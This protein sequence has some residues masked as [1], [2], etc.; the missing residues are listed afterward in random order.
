VLGDKKYAGTGNEL[1]LAQPRQMLHA[2]RLIFPH[3]RTRETIRAIAPL[4]PDF[5]KC[6]A[7]MKLR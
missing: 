2:Y 1:S 4:P 7:Q 6:L 3:P 5:K